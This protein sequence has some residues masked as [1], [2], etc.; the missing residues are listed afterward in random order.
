VFCFLPLI[1]KLIIESLTAP[2]INSLSHIWYV[3]SHLSMKEGIVCIV[4]FCLVCSY[5]IHQTGML[6][7]VISVILESSREGGVHF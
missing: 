2:Q 3:V 4:L 7:I 1:F 5:E 6:Q